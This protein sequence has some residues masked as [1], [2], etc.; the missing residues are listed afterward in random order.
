MRSCR[1]CHFSTSRARAFPSWAVLLASAKNS[2][3]PTLGGWP[4]NDF[5]MEWT[6]RLRR[7]LQSSVQSTRP[8][9]SLKTNPACCLPPSVDEIR[10]R[11]MALV[12]GFFVIES[13]NGV[14][15]RAD[16]IRQDTFFDGDCLKVE[17]LALA[18]FSVE[19]AFD[20]VPRLTIPVRKFDV[21][22]RCRR[23][24]GY[25]QSCIRLRPH[26]GPF[27]PLT[28]LIGS[29]AAVVGENLGADGPFATGYVDR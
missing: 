2:S 13:S 9:K 26:R 10:E 21:A 12:T 7:F 19:R 3:N 29:L 24:H 25:L 1:L 17:L 23:S 4:G 15:E 27:L 14:Q 18:A 22:L 11:H 8:A 20:A 16:P 28:D 5:A 6:A